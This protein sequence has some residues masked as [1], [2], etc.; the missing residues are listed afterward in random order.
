MPI[1][2][3]GRVYA[4]SYGGKMVALDERTGS[5]L[6]Q[7]EIGTSE[8]IWAAGNHLF[9]L[10]TGN[11]VAALGSDTGTIRW[12]TRLPKY[13]DPKDK[14]GPLIFKGPVLAGGR[15]IVAG[16]EGRII[17]IEPQNGKILREWSIGED[18][19]AAPVVASNALFLLTRD[20]KLHAFQ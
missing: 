15:L 9:V 3:K 11:E 14:E 7:R 8:T 1:I 2:D 6:W 18:I 17:E 20:G 19:I 5:R 12:V 16:T 10:A 4:A 13:A